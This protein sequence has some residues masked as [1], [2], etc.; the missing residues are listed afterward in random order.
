MLGLFL[1]F[2]AGLVWWPASTTTPRM[3]IVSRWWSRRINGRQRHKNLEADKLRDNARVVRELASLLRSGQTLDGAL[4]NLG[5]IEEHDASVVRALGALKLRHRGEWGGQRTGASTAE[6]S[7]SRLL[8]RLEW[9]VDICA[10]SGAPLAHVLD[11]L[12]DDVEASLDA[13]RSFDVAMAGPRATTT[14]LTWLPVLGLF[15]ATIFGVDLFSTFGSSL[16]GQLALGLGVGL[17][18][19]N[20]WWCRWL[21]VRSTCQAVG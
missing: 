7:E 9:C 19:A 4:T 10:E 14:L 15:G 17:W 1:I 18:F 13:R 6:S 20:R 8:E 12:A 21:L 16:A 11:Q 3:R 2:V 5:N